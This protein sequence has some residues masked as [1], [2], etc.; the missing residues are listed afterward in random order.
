[1]PELLAALDA[2]LQEHRRCGDLDAGIEPALVWMA[3]D[4]GA[5]LVRALDEPS[6]RSAIGEVDSPYLRCGW[7]PPVTS[8]VGIWEMDRASPRLVLD[9]VGSEA[10]PRIS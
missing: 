4:C 2:F 9:P 5:E 10:G 6:K 3:C 1:M 7:M 8:S